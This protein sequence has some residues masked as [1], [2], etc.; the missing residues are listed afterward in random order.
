LEFFALAR[1]IARALLPGT[2]TDEQ[3]A[4]ARALGLE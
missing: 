3:K 2:V 4:V 1:R